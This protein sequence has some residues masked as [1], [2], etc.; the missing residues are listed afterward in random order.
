M[1]ICVLGCGL[2]TP[3]LI[4][5]LVHSTLQH[6]RNR[7][8]RPGSRPRSADGA[9]R[10]RNRYGHTHRVNEDVDVH[11]ALEGSNFVISSIRVGNMETRAADE[12]LALECGFAGQ[13]TTGP[14][15]FAMALRTIPVALRYA[16]IVER[17]APSAWFVNFTN[18]AGIVTQAIS[19]HTGARVVGIC[20][21]PAE[22]LVSDCAGAR[23]SP[24]NVHCEYFGL[25][26]LGWVS[27][28]RVGGKEMMDQLLNEDALS[29]RLYPT[30]LFSP[31]LLRP[32]G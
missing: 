23:R 24:S 30:Q 26:H 9:D 12:R 19:N 2:R 20:D 10:V 4:H 25:N 22:L 6:R 32:S 27:S 28:V 1:K 17:L 29:R 14:A 18:P 8:V 5:G 11:R 7:A 15:G 3:L 13:E 16:R 31:D 21:T